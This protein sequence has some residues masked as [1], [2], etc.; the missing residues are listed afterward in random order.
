MKTLAEYKKEQIAD[1]AFAAEYEKQRPEMDVI[2]AIVDAR[3]R[4]HLTQQQLAHQSGINQSDIS[5]L[6]NGTRN[7]TIGLLRR[8][9][10]GMGLALKIEF[11]PKPKY[12]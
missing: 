3:E 8:L 5:K 12:A 2:R 9:A 6:E 4:L 1:P 11:V 10:D 7:P